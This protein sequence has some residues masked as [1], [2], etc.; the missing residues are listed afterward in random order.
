MPGGRYIEMNN[1][2]DSNTEYAECENNNKKIKIRKQYI[3]KSGNAENRSWAVKPLGRCYTDGAI[4]T[5]HPHL[6]SLHFASLLS[7][8]FT[9]L[10]YFPT[11]LSEHMRFN[12]GSPNRPFR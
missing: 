2:F 6:T 11:P 1:T 12:E 4:Q 10:I 3:R 8:Y 5:M 9:S 7:S